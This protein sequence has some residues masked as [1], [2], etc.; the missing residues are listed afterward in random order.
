MTVLLI[1]ATIYFCV[2]VAAPVIGFIFT[3]FRDR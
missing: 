3:G 1:A 2:T